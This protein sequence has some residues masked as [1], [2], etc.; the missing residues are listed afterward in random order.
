MHSIMYL[1]NFNV[2]D[3]ILMDDQNSGSILEIMILLENDKKAK[4]F[5]LVRNL[6]YKVEI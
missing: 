6:K 2:S 5:K 4:E 3:S 1:F